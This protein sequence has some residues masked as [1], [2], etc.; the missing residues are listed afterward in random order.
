MRAR[1]GY[2]FG[3]RFAVEAALKALLPIFQPLENR[4]EL[5]YDP[6]G[7]NIDLIIEL[8]PLVGVGVLPRLGDDDE[9]GDEDSL[10]GENEREDAERR[11]VEPMDHGED[12]GVDQDPKREP[13]D[14][15]GQKPRLGDPC[16]ESLRQALMP[17]RILFELFEDIVELTKRLMAFGIGAEDRI[18]IVGP[19][20]GRAD[21]W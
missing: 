6:I 16:R 4:F 11:R 9:D 10:D 21:D 8:G 13:D 12:A 7:P 2:L 14:V 18:V 19:A 5:V 1:R 15:R 17:P 20:A 3:R